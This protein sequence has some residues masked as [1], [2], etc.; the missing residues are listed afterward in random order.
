MLQFGTLR[1][2]SS[3]RRMLAFWRKAEIDQSLFSNL[4]L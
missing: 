4:D 1:A 3:R 2:R